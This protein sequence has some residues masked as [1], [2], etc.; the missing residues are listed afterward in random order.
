MSDLKETNFDLS[1]NNPSKNY[2]FINVTFIKV[3][4]RH[5]LW[6][7]DFSEE[8]QPLLCTGNWERRYVLEVYRKIAFVKTLAKKMENSTESTESNMCLTKKCLK[9]SLTNIS[10]D[11]AVTNRFVWSIAKSFFRN[12]WFCHDSS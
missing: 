1:T 2:R 3:I 4:E 10:K 5:A 8:I 9:K 6:K 11:S 12:C 7:R